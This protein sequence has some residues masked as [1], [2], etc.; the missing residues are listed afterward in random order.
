MGNPFMEE[1]DDL[2]A[3]DTKQIM[4][5]GALAILRK[6]EEVG[7]AQYESFIAERL[8]QQSKSMYDPIK[9]NNL[10]V[11]NEP[12]SNVASK[13]KQQLS[14]ARN[15]CL[16]FSRLYISCQTREGNLDETPWQEI[17]EAFLS[18]ISIYS[19]SCCLT[20]SFKCLARERSKYLQ[21][22]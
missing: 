13:T 22:C 15:D 18:R 17:T 19:R 7:M 12:A 3:L 11:F 9:R 5:S 1:T 2:L 6:V 21:K 20:S 4:S 8:M 16:L 14:S 10:R